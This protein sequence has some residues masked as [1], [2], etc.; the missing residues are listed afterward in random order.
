MIIATALVALLLA[1]PPSVRATSFPTTAVVG[2]PWQATLAVR[3]AAAVTVNGVRAKALGKGRFRATLTFTREGAVPVTAR[4]GK[5]TFRLGS[6]RV[7]VRADPALLDPLAVA[8]DTDGSVLVGQLRQGAL[9]RLGSGPVASGVG[10][11]HVIVANGSTYAAGQD[12][13]IY[14]VESG[15]FVPLTPA[16]DAGSVAV[17]PD[18]T[19][20]WTHYES[21]T[22]R[23]LRGGAITVVAGGFFHP[24]QLAL[25]GNALYVSD[26]ENRRIER[27]DLAT[28]VVTTVGGDVGITVD[29]AV[30]PDG[31]VYSGD[32][33]RDGAGGGVVRIS[34]DGTTTRIYGKSTSG[35]AVAPDGSVYAVAL[36]EKRIVHLVG[37]RWETVAR[38]S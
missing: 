15:S 9:L 11:F 8:V 28:G 10:T 24:H 27:I 16:V 31:T 33:V 6:V 17:G 18:G 34:P 25:H 3:N 30:A 23:A 21:G 14:R 4:V 2:A 12:G 22:V 13:R 19:V 29:L 35:V 38:G 20:Y 37:G 36:D 7:D 1:A 26:T 5:R 32:V